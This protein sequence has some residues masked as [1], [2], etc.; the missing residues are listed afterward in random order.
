M[1]VPLAESGAPSSFDV[2]DVVVRCR[3]PA[4]RSAVRTLGPSVDREQVRVLDRRR[5]RRRPSQQ[6]HGSGSPLMPAVGASI[7]AP[8]EVDVVARDRRRLDGATSKLMPKKILKI[9]PSSSTPSKS[10]NCGS[11]ESTPSGADA[12]VVVDS[13]RRLGRGRRSSSCRRLRRRPRPRRRRHRRRRS[14]RRRR[15]PPPRARRPPAAALRRP[16]AAG[17]RR[18]AARQGARTARAVASRWL[19]SGRG[20]G[21]SASRW[22]ARRPRHVGSRAPATG[23]AS[24]G[25]CCRLGERRPRRRERRPGRRPSLGSTS[26]AT[27]RPRPVATIWATSGTRDEPPD[28]QDGVELVR[29]DAGACAGPARR[30]RWCRTRTGRTRL[31]NSAAGDPDVAAG[32]AG[33]QHVDDCV[34]VARQ[35][36][37]R[38]RA[39]VAEV[40]EGGAGRRV[41]AVEVHEQ[42]VGRPL[43]VTEHGLVEVDPAEALD[44]LGLADAARSCR[45]CACGARRRRRCR[46]RGRRPPRRRRRARAAWAA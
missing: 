38:R 12:V 35:L 32:L 23:T 40:V 13:V 37:L 20:A 6:L 21:G 46:R 3:R 34:D 1:Q 9:R 16:V 11:D 25:A 17:R 42:V 27:G 43:D 7:V 29:V 22:S 41:V 44:A 45:R 33:Q 2:G 26:T 10:A 19:R 4:R 36:L 31:S 30:S 15:R 24:A 5:R 18:V 8:E 28:E 14:S 39:L